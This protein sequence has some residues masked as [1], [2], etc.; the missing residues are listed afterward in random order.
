[1][2]V[3]Y[4]FLYLILTRHKYTLS[5]DSGYMLLCGL[6][7]VSSLRFYLGNPDWFF[8]WLGTVKSR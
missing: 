3:Q 6:F 7:L 2:Y 1:M 4:E 8:K 5:L